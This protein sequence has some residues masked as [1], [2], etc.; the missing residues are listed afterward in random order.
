MLDITDLMSGGQAI[1]G[2]VGDG[3][4]AGECKVAQIFTPLCLCRFS[5][6]QMHTLDYGVFF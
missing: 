4:S 5:P 6:Y 2:V 1:G 3:V